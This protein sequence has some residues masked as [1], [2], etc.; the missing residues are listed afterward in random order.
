[1]GGVF[2]SIDYRNILNDIPELNYIITGEGEY[3]IYKLAECIRNNYEKEVELIEGIAFRN[4]DEI[5]SIPANRINDL[6]S[7]PFPK[8]EELKIENMQFNIRRI[9]AGRGCY[10]QCTFC[11]IKSSY[12]HSGRIYREAKNVV[13]EIEYL[14]KKY[15]V[16]Y[17]EFSD[18]IFYERSP[19]GRKWVKDF[20]TEILSRKIKIT[21]RME[22]RVDDVLE[23]EISLVHI[24]IDM[25]LGM[26]GMPC[27]WAFHLVK[28]RLA[29]T[30]QRG[31]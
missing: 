9:I 7:L 5:V 17:F 21:F 10:G 26:K 28:Q 27:L 2:A 29:Y 3:S 15:N 24:I 12:I 31:L 30:L 6:S 25:N 1:M 20:A 4:T 16:T 13:D 19:R 18:D 23:N 11:S 14:M 22:I 8:R